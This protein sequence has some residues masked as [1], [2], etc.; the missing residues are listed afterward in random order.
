MAAKVGARRPSCWR[1]SG[2]TRHSNLSNDDNITQLRV[3]LVESAADRYAAAA[4]T[5]AFGLYADGYRDQISDAGA[6]DLNP[7][8]AGY[9]PALLD[10]AVLDALCRATGTSVADAIARNL[11]GVVVTDLTPDLAGFDL[12]GFLPSLRLAPSIHVRHTV[13]LGRSDCRRRRD[14]RRLAEN[15]G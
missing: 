11:P 2:S 1:R 10:K 3:S 14:C 4:A 13:G 5:T 15:S 7:L 12:D 8:V 9:G 6:H